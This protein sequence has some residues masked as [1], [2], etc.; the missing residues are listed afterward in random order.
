MMQAPKVATGLLVLLLH[1]AASADGEWGASSARAPLCPEVEN[2]SPLH[3]FEQTDFSLALRMPASAGH[4]TRMR[5]RWIQISARLTRLHGLPIDICSGDCPDLESFVMAPPSVDRI[6]GFEIQVQHRDHG[7]Q[8][9]TLYAIPVRVYPDDLLT[10]IKSWARENTL[11]VRDRDGKLADFLQDQEVAFV[12]RRPGRVGRRATLELVTGDGDGIGRD[13]THGRRRVVLFPEKV[14][15]FPKIVAR[16]D[17]QGER[18]RVEMA[19]LDRL[20]T[21]RAQMILLETFRM[22][23]NTEGKAP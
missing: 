10:P 18:V 16:S 19:L 4:T 8:W 12:T 14:R 6:T 20:D 2:E 23:L 7:S 3:V 22:S 11:I 21:P 9:H 1:G 5:A 13:D 17:E 15:D